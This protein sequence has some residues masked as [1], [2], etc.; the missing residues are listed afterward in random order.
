MHIAHHYYTPAYPQYVSVARYRH[1]LA[2]APSCDFSHMPK[3][4][5]GALYHVIESQRRL[6]PEIQTHANA[7]LA[8]EKALRPVLFYP[9][10]QPSLSLPHHPLPLLSCIPLISIDL[11]IVFFHHLHLDNTHGLPKFCKSGPSEAAKSRKK[12]LFLGHSAL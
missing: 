4:R 5:G 2:L 11:F 10:L 3:G 6:G 8:K 9:I 12:D 1:A 7:N